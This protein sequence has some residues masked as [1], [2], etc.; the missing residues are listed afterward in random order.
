LTTV[1]HDGVVVVSGLPTSA[2]TIAATAHVV[3]IQL[4]WAIWI[5]TGDDRV[6]LLWGAFMLCVLVV[7]VERHLEYLTGLWSDENE[8]VFRG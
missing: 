1:D 6:D 2:R 3:A 4:R 8:A 7:V 5:D